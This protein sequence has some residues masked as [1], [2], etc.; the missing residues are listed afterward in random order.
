LKKIKISFILL[1][2]TALILLF[3]PGTTSA[4]L[5]TLSDV[6]TRLQKSPVTSSHDI[7]FTF[8]AG[9]KLDPT[10]TVAIDFHEDD[11]DFTVAGAATVVGDLD[12]T[13]GGVEADIVD[14]DGSCATHTGADDIVASINDTTGVLT[15]TAC[16]NYN[17]GINGS[18]I[19]IEYGTAAAGPGTNRV[20]NP[21]A[22][23]SYIIDITAAGETGKLAVAIVD[24]DQFTVSASV[25]PSITLQLSAIATDFG[26][27]TTS[28]KTSSPNITLT[29]DTNAQNGYAITVQD[30][31]NATNPGLYNAGATFLIGSADYSYNNSADLGAVAGYGIQCSSASATCVAPYNVAGDNVGGYELIA[32]SFATYN[33][34]AS[35]HTVTITSKARVTG[36]TPAGNY[37]DTVTVICTGQ[38]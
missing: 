25:D 18:I 29:I 33:G 15:F 21:V 38:F 20:T 36:A 9:N 19:N 28:V 22:A 3:Y 8:G 17:L 11:A 13:D 27:V 4:A 2:L 35:A 6:M 1:L 32:T 16:E 7:L 26:T 31:G 10:E 12:F 5:S 14:V 23:G 34:T 24:N 37:T 30:A